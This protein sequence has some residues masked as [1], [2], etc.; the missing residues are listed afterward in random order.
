MKRT[1]TL[2]GQDTKFLKLLGRTVTSVIESIGVI[3]V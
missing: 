1:N 2:C 3:S